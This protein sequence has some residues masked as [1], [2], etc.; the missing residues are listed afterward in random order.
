M[1]MNTAYRSPR[2]SISRSLTASLLRLYD[3]PDPQKP[4]RLIKG[5]DKQHA[6]RTA[7]M[8]AAVA[9]QLGFQQPVLTQYEISCLLHDLG[10][11]GLD[12]TLFGS[13]WSW[14][15]TNG[16]PTRPA[17]WRVK[18]P[19]TPYGK[20]TEAFI[21]R[22]RHQLER[23]GI[24]MN[25]WACE[26]IEMRLGFGRRLKRHIRR[27]RPTLKQLGVNWAPWMEKIMLY[28]YYPEKLIGSSS[29]VRQLGE[30]LVACEQLEAYSNRQRGRDYYTRTKESF[31]DAFRYLDSLKKRGVLTEPVV[32]TIYGLV[33]EGRF[34]S[35]LQSACGRHFSLKEIR[36]LR[37][38]PLR[39]T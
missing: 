14:A 22:Y 18:Y 30:V 19:Q 5:Y 16:V 23:H 32:K 27:V 11:T 24:T 33:K 38:L 12:H 28:Y 9:R 29:W 34:D 31:T 6:L 2:L 7:K 20:E 13:I 3:Y 17:E 21:T 39:E 37:T 8:S 26:Q 1:A 25:S 15:R 36:L 35:L 4:G 10:R